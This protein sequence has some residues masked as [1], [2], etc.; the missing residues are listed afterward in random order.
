MSKKRHVRRGSL[1][2]SDSGV[3]RRDF[4]NS[5]LLG[6]GA[7]LLDMAAPIQL[8][9][10]E[11]SWDGYGGIGDYANSHGNT[12]AVLSAAHAMRDGKYK[13]LPSDT[14]DTR[15]IYD[16]AVVGGGFAG[17]A[18]AY[19]F[20]KQAR[21]GQKCIV[22][23]NHPIFGGEAKRNEFLVD[24]CRI[25]G[26]QGSNTFAVPDRSMMAAEPNYDVYDDLGIPHHFQ[27]EEL[28]AN[29]KRRLEFARDNYGFMWWSDRSPSIGLFFDA[30]KFGGKSSWQSDVWDRKLENTP[31][32]QELKRNF[33]TWRNSR[34]NYHEGQDFERWLDTM[35]YKQYVEK[36]MG[37]RQQITEYAD[38]ILAASIGLGSD[39]TSAYA[40]YSIGMPGFKG[41]QSGFKAF[42]SEGEPEYPMKLEEMNFEAF[43]GGNC[44]LA[45]YFVKWLI[46]EGI[47]GG[48]GLNDIIGRK[49][50]FPS[51]DAVANQIRIRT[52]STVVWVQHEGDVSKADLVTIAYVRNGRVERFQ[53]RRV[54]MAC[55][56]WVNLY[57]IRDLPTE[58]MHAC[59]QF[60][61]SPMLVVNV[62]LRHW[63][64]LYD[65]GLTACRWFDGFGFS[66]NI[67][68]SMVVEGFRQ[69][70][71]PD[72]P[73]VLT[74][75]VPF[76]YPGKDIADQ[77]VM[78]RT[79]LLSTGYAEYER[80][81]KDQMTKLFGAAGFNAEKDIAGIVLN[82]WGHAYVD[83][84]PG[85]YFGID[86][87]PAP[88][89]ILRKRF[90]RISIGHSELRGFQNWIGAVAEGR[91][92]ARD[93][94]AVGD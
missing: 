31:F 4:L 61:R 9:G 83:P 43:P 23:E 27:Y 47:D 69:P 60:H 50:N 1:P 29:R 80:Q 12:F 78:G 75:Y 51:L 85:F 7:I 79:E 66:C 44:G 58:H 53:A 48:T 26:P 62:A 82:R 10:S 55:G 5:T 40:A 21:P 35:T 92:A 8:F 38:P 25:A 54:V 14:L 74:F 57:A 46:P 70:L 77:G 19:E 59:R 24:G 11:Q 39:V 67:R 2:A 86:G 91:R 37:L 16:L 64:F 52:D 71:D 36:V 87:K 84:Q 13:E 63:R 76:Y 93:V 15:E 6:A 18:A 28:P 90:G 88:S 89:D 22:L 73:V 3:T 17:L 30:A 42:E 49:V 41:F 68:R 32:S 56:N 45:R 65:L 33:E 94:L 72:R 34:K 20:K 81:I